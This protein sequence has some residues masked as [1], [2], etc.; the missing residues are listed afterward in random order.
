MVISYFI[1]L[2]YKGVR[3]SYYGV[4]VGSGIRDS[5]GVGTGGSL[6]V[7]SGVGDSVGVGTGVSLGVGETVGALGI[8]DCPVLFSKIHQLNELSAA[9]G[10]SSVTVN[11]TPG[12][13]VTK[14]RVAGS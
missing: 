6:G 8:P 10:A 5:V 3:R 9:T 11:P 13:L 2:E 12:S 1:L 7:G 4:G 14:K